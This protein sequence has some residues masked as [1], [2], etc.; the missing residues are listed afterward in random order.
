MQP[1]RPRRLG[2][3]EVEEEAARER[4][5]DARALFHQDVPPELAAGAFRPARGQ[6]EARLGGTVAAVGLGTS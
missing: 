1:I 4:Y 5:D 6:P 2:P 3:Y